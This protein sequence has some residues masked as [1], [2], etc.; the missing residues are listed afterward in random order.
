MQHDQPIHPP[1]VASSSI[2]NRSAWIILL[3]ILPYWINL[4]GP[5]L[6]DSTEAFYTET[7]REMIELNSY[8]VPYFN[9]QPRLNKPPLAY[10]LVIPFY[11]LFGAEH[12]V[13][14]AVNAL[15]ASLLVV[16]TW[17]LARRLFTQRAGLLAAAMIATTPRLLLIAQKSLIDTYFTLLV[18]AALFFFWRSVERDTSAA[19]V[20]AFYVV[21]GL[22][23]LTKGP[24]ALVLTG[25]IGLL[26]LLMT[27]RWAVVHHMKIPIGVL[28]LVGIVVPWYVAVYLRV[29]WEPIAA[30]IF[31]DNIGRFTSDIDWSERGHFFYG[32]VLLADFFPWSLYLV[33]ACVLGYRLWR[34][35]ASQHASVIFLLLWIAFMLMF[36]S[37][38]RNKQEYYLLPL[39]PAAAAL[40]AHWFDRLMEGAATA[41][42]QRS[43]Q[44]ITVLAGLTL[45][46][47]G[48]LIALFMH[49]VLLSPRAAAGMILPIIGAGWLLW[50][51]RRQKLKRM[52]VAL[53]GVVVLGVVLYQSV[54]LPVIEPLRPTRP[55][56]E[57]I[58]RRAGPDDLIGA[59]KYAAPSLTF[60][61]R[62][63]I[64]EAFL[65]EVMSK[66]LQSNR[67]IFCLVY[68]QDLAELEQMAP[69]RLTIL[70]RR[71]I[72]TWRL[73][74]LWDAQARQQM[75]QLLLVAAGE[76]NGD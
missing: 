22:A 2:A 23:V 70:E 67:R 10:W 28:I 46:V 65:P 61:L 63:P 71:P 47:G 18:V 29:G 35:R 64:F 49:R 8:V 69:G 9:Y 45:V 19:V 52:P 60:Y 25:G 39:Y 21:L 36:F 15:G 4:S 56:A 42:E 55:L 41:W 43:A 48:I 57:V 5:S 20:L 11:H 40:V 1:S 33:P 53:A 76:A 16:L 7:P 12:L 58:A 62:R 66:I 31:R 24:L 75:P 54:Y 14:R 44:W 68:E 13:A 37:L 27:G 73:N 17:A 3:L 38:A 50:H 59:Y 51:V 72:L 32:S 74:T 30:F 34:S 6:W 26:F